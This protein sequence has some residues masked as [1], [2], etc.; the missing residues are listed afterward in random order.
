MG[1]FVSHPIKLQNMD[2]ISHYEGNKS[3]E[4]ENLSDQNFISDQNSSE[5]DSLNDAIKSIFKNNS[6][7]FLEEDDES[8]IEQKLYFI[9]VNSIKKRKQIFKVIYHNCLFTETDQIF[10]SYEEEKLFLGRKRSSIRQGRLKDNDNI[11]SK[12]KRAFCN[13]LINILNEEL[14][15][16]GSKK[17]FEKFPNVFAGDVTRERNKDIVNMELGEIFTNEKLY[18]N[19]EENG[20][21]NFLHN[22][23]VVRSEEIKKNKK[24]KKYLNMTFGELYE[25][26]IYSD[27]FLTDK[28]NHLKQKGME[29]KYIIKLKFLAKGLIEFFEN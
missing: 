13:A 6:N 25:E 11:R 28:I 19:E 27:E 2:T 17:Y 3:I 14:R 4:I 23:N 5:N 16:I 10:L 24:F 9:K 8:Q 7:S 15:S 18:I 29:D 21:K 26:Y 1:T 20:L 22:S 12:L